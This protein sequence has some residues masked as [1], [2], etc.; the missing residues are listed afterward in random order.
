VVADSFNINIVPALVW[1]ALRLVPA[2]VVVECR[3]R[4]NVKRSGR[5]N[6]SVGSA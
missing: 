1:F 5:L 3:K 6:R 4:I 2:D